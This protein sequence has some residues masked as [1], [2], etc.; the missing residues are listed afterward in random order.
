MK[1]SWCLRARSCKCVH[2]SGDAERV[3]CEDGAGAGRDR[4]LDCSGVEIERDEIQLNEDG[5][6]AHLKDSIDHGHERKR[7]NDDLIAFAH[8]QRE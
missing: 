7:G 6:G 4:A 2:L 1:E 8:T 5:R 3:D